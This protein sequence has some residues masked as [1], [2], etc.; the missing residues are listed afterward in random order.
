[1]SKLLLVFL[2]LVA[3]AS[4]QRQMGQAGL[5]LLENAEGFVATFYYDQ[6]GQKTIGYGHACIWHNNCDDI[7]P[8]ITEAQGTQIL[9][10]DLVEFEQCVQTAAPNLNQNQFDACVDFAF[11]M[12]CGAFQ[13]SDILTNINAGNFQAAA[14]AFTEYNV[15]GG[16]VIDGLTVRRQN[17]KNLFLS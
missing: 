17:E 7:T 14:N 10:S 2:V 8:P 1:M 6:I 9:M 3:Y 4:A 5:N 15:A 12:G 13:S 11:N 16:Q